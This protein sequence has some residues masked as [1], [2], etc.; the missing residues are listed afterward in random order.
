[1]RDALPQASWGAGAAVQEERHCMRSALRQGTAH[2][3][4]VHSKDGSPLAPRIETHPTV[5]SFDA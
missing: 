3:A 1:M 4:G 2:L 5:P